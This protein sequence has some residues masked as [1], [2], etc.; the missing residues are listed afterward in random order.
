MIFATFMVSCMVR[1]R[2]RPSASPRPRPQPWARPAPASASAQRISRRP[3]RFGFRL[4]VRLH[5]CEQAPRPLRHAPGAVHAE[6]LPH[7]RRA[8]RGAAPARPVPSSSM[9]SLCEFRA[10]RWGPELRALQFSSPPLLGADPCD[11]RRG[12]NRY[13]DCADQG[14]RHVPPGPGAQLTSSRLRSPSLPL[15]SIARCSTCVPDSPPSSPH[16]SA[17]DP[18]RCVQR[19]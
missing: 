7:R 4:A 14:R 19:L 5:N 10:L 17:S 2:P 12:H 3:R 8:A 6:C 16:P 11:R 1:P 18:V 13:A 9:V 15:R